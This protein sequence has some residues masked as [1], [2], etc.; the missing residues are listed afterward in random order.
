M[1][2]SLPAPRPRQTFPEISG[3]SWEHPA[4]RAA[5]QALR[6]IPGVDEVIR[7][8]L[9]LLGGERGVRLLFQGNAV[10]VGPAQFPKLWHLHTE[11]VHH[12]RLAD[13][14]RAVR[15]PDAVLQCRRLRHRPAVHRAPLRGD[16]A[17]RRRRAPGA[18]LPRDG[19]RDERARALPDDRRHSRADQSRRPADARRAWRCFRSGWPSSS[20]RGSRSSRPTARACSAPR[21]SWRRSG[22]T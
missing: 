12:L 10:R 13:G 1:T 20:G 16:R 7:K 2:T 14:A 19:P 17:A 8:T 21:T 3:V 18:A 4:D 5:L 15:L 22:S 6:A 11:V 9:A